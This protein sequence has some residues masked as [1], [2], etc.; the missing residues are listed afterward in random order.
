MTWRSK[1][2]KTEEIALKNEITLTEESHNML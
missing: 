1:V 2:V